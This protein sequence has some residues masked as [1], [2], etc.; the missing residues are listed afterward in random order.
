MTKNSTSSNSSAWT[1]MVPVDDTALAVTDTGGPGMPVVYLNGQFATQGY[2]RRVIADLGT[3]W[4]PSPAVAR[5]RP[6]EPVPV[7]PSRRAPS[8]RPG[9]FAAPLREQRQELPHP[10]VVVRPGGDR[11]DV[12]VADGLVARGHVGVAGRDL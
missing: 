7:D 12:S 8:L 10:H 3:G 11:D 1:G 2:W 4:R 9:R 5:S 6:P